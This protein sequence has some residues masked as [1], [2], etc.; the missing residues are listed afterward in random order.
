MISPGQGCT[1]C[2]G[3]AVAASTA[4]TALSVLVVTECHFRTHE[5]VLKK[6]GVLVA[7]WLPAVC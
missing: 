2:H 6:N 5:C 4:I 3:L 1:D 7:S